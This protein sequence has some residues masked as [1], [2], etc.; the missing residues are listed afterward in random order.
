MDQQVLDKTRKKVAALLRRADELAGKR[1]VGRPRK[2]REQHELDGTYR[3]DRHGP[4]RP[5]G[6]LVYPAKP[7]G[8]VTASAR[9]Q[10][11]WIQNAA[12]ERAVA[13]GHRFNERLA[14]HAV[15]FFPEFLRF[16]EGSR[17]AGEPFEP[18][19]WQ[20]EDLLY[21]LFG[22]VKSDGTRRFRRA[23]IE[24]PKKNLKSTT[25]AGIGLYGFTA[26][27]EPGARVFSYGADK[28]QAKIVHGHAIDMVDAS[29]ELSA[30][31]KVNRS[32]GVIS[33]PATKSSYKAESASPRGKHGPSTHFGIY[34]E[35]HE[36]YG[37]QLWNA[38]RYAYRGR[39]EPLALVITNAGDDVQSV[40]YAQRE[41]A[42]AVLAGKVH[43]DEFFGLVFRAN[44]AEA[45]AEIEAVGKGATELPVAARCNPAM[46]H[47]ISKDTLI[48]DIKDAITTSSEMPNLLRLTYGIW[49]T[50][51]SPWLSDADWARCAKPFTLAEMEGWECYGGL[52]LS[53]TGD[54]T[55][56]ALVFPVPGA[57]D[58][59]RLDVHFWLPER[60]VEKRRHLIVQLDEWERGGWL[61][62]VPGP[63][64]DYGAIHDDL[65]RCDERFDFRQL[66]FDRKYAG[67]TVRFIDENLEVEPIEF[68]Q[69]MEQFAGPT[70]DFE[71]L[72]QASRLLHNDNGTLNWQAGHCQVY[73]DANRNKRP[74]KQKE[75]D[76]RSIDGMVAG[77][78]ALA[79]AV[80]R[81]EEESDYDE[82]EC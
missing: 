3:A 5:G 37:D 4:K 28:D 18:T 31:L 77:V 34:D 52:D 78:M 15:E 46:G 76:I 40:C 11:R 53:K 19:P 33:Y 68:G 67:Q 22:W 24:I 47:V 2:T 30:V 26:D 35:L 38:L 79:L 16:S 56:R 36:W 55:A 63:E 75:G 54:M 42:L 1:P 65:A 57:D 58:T 49:H 64:I 61:T 48:A 21:P 17:W 6:L 72:V 71:R 23:Y 27:G 14:R 70:A 39:T 81:D 82:I 73:T 69:T 10:S 45:E 25:A 12:D 50:G 20:V 44:R 59:Y 8:K 74:V 29:P 66:A 60:T 51:K 7:P 32:T 13:E 80:E 9:S 62:I 43:D 41:K